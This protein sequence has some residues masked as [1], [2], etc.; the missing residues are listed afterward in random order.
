ME[1]IT[2]TSPKLKNYKNIL[3]F[4]IIFLTVII[5][6]E[7]RPYVS[8]ILGACTLYIILQSQ[9]IYLVEK[10]ELKKSLAST[11]LTLEALLLFLIPLTVFAWMI[12]STISDLNIDPEQLMN[13][14]KYFVSKIE[15]YAGFRINITD[16]TKEIP[17]FGTTIVQGLGQGMYS[18][19]INTFVILF[20]LYY[21]L[22]NYKEF[23][24]GFKEVLPFKD[25]NKQIVAEETKMMIQA[26]AIGIPLLALLQGVFAY[27]GYLLFGVPNALF[28]GIFTGFASIIPLLGTMIIWVPITI[29]QIIAG[30]YS[31]ALFIF[32]Y[33]L[34]VIGGVDN[35]ARFM[36]QKKIADIHPLITIFGVFV[37]IPLFGFWGVIFGPL[38]ISSLILFFNM[39]RHEYIPGSLAEPRV[40][41]RYK[42]KTFNLPTYK[43]SNKRDK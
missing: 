2:P 20:L 27:L 43:N 33:G 26:N 28:Y 25:E 19:I 40:T 37:G 8:G 5:L 10:K 30:D 38:I 41:T 17:K 36:L 16:F 35:V 12:I 23:D 32:L 24:R 21:M 3:V 4:L 9:M 29:A 11:I 6:K 7:I 15:N 14:F 34:I 18:M 42:V 31:N 1:A 13:N 39:Y 22:Y